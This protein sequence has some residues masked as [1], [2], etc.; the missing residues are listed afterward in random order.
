MCQH[1]LTVMADDCVRSML[2]HVSVCTMCHTSV[3]QKLENSASECQVRMT[4][5]IVDIS[6]YIMPLTCFRIYFCF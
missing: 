2:P 6:T 4:V 3:G 5:S 1:L